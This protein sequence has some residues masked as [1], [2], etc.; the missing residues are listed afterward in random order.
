MNRDTNDLSSFFLFRIYLFTLYSIHYIST[1]VMYR[2]YTDT[3]R[4]WST[5]VHYSMKK[6]ETRKREREK[7]ERNLD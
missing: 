6:K 3:N 4:S 7:L 2:F 1:P 5:Y